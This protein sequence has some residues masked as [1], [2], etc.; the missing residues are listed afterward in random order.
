M[1]RPD[2]PGCRR[3]RPVYR[4]RCPEEALDLASGVEVGGVEQGDADSQRQP[5]RREVPADVTA[6][7]DECAGAQPDRR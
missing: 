5:D 7:V 4:R 1:R 2:R 6:A 3:C